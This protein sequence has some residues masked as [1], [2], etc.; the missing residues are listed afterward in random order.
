MSKV[1]WHGEEFTREVEQEVSKRMFRAGVIVL[2]EAVRSMKRAKGGRERMHKRLKSG[3]ISKS[4]FSRW[5][6]TRRSAPGEPPAV[7]TGRLSRSLSFWSNEGGLERLSP[8]RWRVGTNVEYAK[9]L[10]SAKRVFIWKR[11]LLARPFL[12]PAMEATK[13]K[14]QAL[15][16]K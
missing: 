3:R 15:F 9:F 7:Q 11:H 10:E 8:L 12:K 1:D 14:I 13:A 6:K 5:Q 2:S 16:N 4:Q